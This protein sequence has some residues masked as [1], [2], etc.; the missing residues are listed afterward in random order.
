MEGKTRRAPAEFCDVRWRPQ[1]RRALKPP[2]CCAWKYAALQKT[3]CCVR[4]ET[5]SPQKKNPKKT[6]GCHCAFLYPPLPLPSRAPARLPACPPARLPAC[7]PARLRPPPLP[8][9]SGQAGRRAGGLD[10]GAP[11]PGLHS[12]VAAQVG[13]TKPARWQ[14][15]GKWGCAGTRDRATKPSRGWLRVVVR[16]PRLV[17]AGFRSGDTELELR[18]KQGPTGGGCEREIKQKTGPFGKVRLSSRFCVFLR[19][20]AG[21]NQ[22][23][24]GSSRGHPPRESHANWLRSSVGPVKN[25]RFLEVDYLRRFRRFL[26]KK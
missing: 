1:N 23:G 21:N 22:P 3:P 19:G 2:A 8:S 4:R 26:P 7:P 12:R 20:N 5:N 18:R 10:A 9:S 25:A 16:K 6:A 24:A 15:P 14:T 17:L 11:L 13:T